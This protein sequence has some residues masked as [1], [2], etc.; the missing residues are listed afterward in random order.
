[1]K[2]KFYNYFLFSILFIFISGFAVGQN[3]EYIFVENF[4]TTGILPSGWGAFNRNQPGPTNYTGLN[5]PALR[6]DRLIM[7]MQRLLL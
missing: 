6:L 4:E 3:S 2:N 5:L 1:M 7:V